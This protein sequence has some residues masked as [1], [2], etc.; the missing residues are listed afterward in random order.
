MEIRKVDVAI[1]GAGTAGMSAYRRVREYTD[2]VVIIESSHY[3]TTCARVGCMP[4]K[5][6]I[7]AAEACHQVHGAARFGV[8]VG[9][10][11]VDGK[12]VMQRVKSERDRFVGFVEETVNDW[13]DADKV[14][15]EARF[16][17]P[18]E[19]QVGEAL[20]IRAQRVVIAV[21]SRPNIPAP[22]YDLGDRLLI[23]DDVFAWDDLPGSVGVVG[24]GVIGLEL[25]QALSRLG[26]RTQLFGVGNRIGPLSDPLVNAQAL[27]IF[28]EE[29]SLSADA[30]VEAV[31]RT[32]DGVEVSYTE[33]GERRTAQFD[34]LIAATG[35]RSNIDRLDLESA[36]LA[37]NEQGL[38]AFDDSTGQIENS[39]VFIA[40]DVSNAHPL[41]HEAADDGRIAGDNAGT[42]PQIHA[43]PRRAPISVVFTDPQ[44]ALVG[45]RYAQLEHSNTAFAIGQVD[46]SGQGRSR[47]IGKNKGL[48]RVYG[49]HGSGLFLG[50]EMI[51]PAAEHLA[52]LLSWS[53]QH[54]LS[55]QQMLDSPFYHPVIEEGLRT[56]LRQLNS[57]L[58]MGP[59][60]VEGCLDCGPG[61]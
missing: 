9:S 33:K 20:R 51:G 2:S 34:Y 37:V 10:V 16:C 29:M 47:V 23:N 8:D 14:W 58:K 56:A 6:L 7:A 28:G 3:G 52:H 42:Y 49:E 13:P 24:T 48:L 35:R 46:F 45:A 41:L 38:P 12:R 39:S 5:L 25:S 26:V 22:W 59:L 27:T 43:R 30:A 61:A 18:N 15:G 4:S 11:A 1:I 54:R 60:P 50:A 17:G 36:G 31:A 21:G 32:D 57:E 44:I 19:L 40:G 55:V 53:V